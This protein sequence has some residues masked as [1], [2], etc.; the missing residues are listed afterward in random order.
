[1]MGEI[2][3][4][5]ECWPEKKHDHLGDPDLDGKIIL[6]QM[7]RKLGTIMDSSGSR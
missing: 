4:T 1:M 2:T 5:K 6:K 7:S 3:N